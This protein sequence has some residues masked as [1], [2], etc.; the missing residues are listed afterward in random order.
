MDNLPDLRAR[1]IPYLSA[2]Q[3]RMKLMAEDALLYTNSNP[4]TE[5]LMHKLI[6]GDCGVH[7]ALRLAMIGHEIDHCAWVMA[8]LHYLG[9][10]KRL[11]TR[12]FREDVIEAITSYAKGNL[13]LSMT[14]QFIWQSWMAT[15]VRSGH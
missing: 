6:D 9:I 14:V 4:T 1:N 13:T 10:L 8:I 12:A 15:V 11:T 2:P 3:V 5:R 7:K